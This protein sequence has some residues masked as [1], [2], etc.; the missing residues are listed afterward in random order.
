MQWQLKMTAQTDKLAIIWTSADPAV[1][2]QAAFMY[3]RNSMIQ[4]WWGRVQ[5]IVWG[6]SAQTLAQDKE[7]QKEIGPLL[8]A[9]VEITACK[10]CADSLGASPALE[11]LGITVKFMG[12]PLTEMLKCGW[13]VVTF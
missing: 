5:L 3:A 6:P 8:E 1:A 10:A 2:R 4:E 7:L 11:A 13:R 12:Q 9:G